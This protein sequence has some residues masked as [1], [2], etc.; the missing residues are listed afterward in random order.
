MQRWLPEARVVKA[1]NIVGNVHMVNPDFPG[2]P[3]D[4][5]LCG[6]DDAAKK[7]VTGFLDAFGWHPVDIGGIEVS[8]YLE[9]L[10]M[11]WIVT[12]F[13]T[14]SGNHALKLLRK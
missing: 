12:C 6:N 7:T 3:P 14:G 8:R 13:Q 9:P 10:A 11:V 4:M 5:F 1:F 2:G